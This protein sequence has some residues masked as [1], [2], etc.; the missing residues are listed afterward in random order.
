MP[1]APSA[2]SP[3]AA[4]PDATAPDT[5][6][7]IA[8]LAIAAAWWLLSDLTSVWGPSLITIFGQA[9]STPAELMGLFALGCVLVAIP[10]A[11]LAKPGPTLWVVLAVAVACRCVLTFTPGGQWQLWSASIG[12]AAA[13][14]W[15]A[16]VLAAHGRQVALGIALGWTI[17]SALGALG[18]T[19]SPVWRADV[20]GIGALVGL[21]GLLGWSATRLNSPAPEADI[22]P[23]GRRQAWTLLPLLLVTGIAIVNP[24]RASAVEPSYGATLLTIGSALAVLVA[25]AG[26]HGVRARV[27]AAVVSVAAVAA[28]LYGTTGDPV[29]GSL[30]TWTFI[31]FL[32]APTAFV[33]LLEPDRDQRPARLLVPLGGAVVWVLGFFAYY[34][35]YDLGYRADLLIVVLAAVI[36]VCAGLATSAQEQRSPEEF[37][38]TPRPILYV[39]LASILLAAGGAALNRMPEPYVFAERAEL[40]VTAWNLRM[41]YGMDGV[42]DPEAVAEI[43]KDSDVVLL[44]EIDRGWLLNG[45][46][47]QLA[48]LARLTDKEL[49]FAPAADPVWGDA[50]LTS[51]PVDEVRGHPLPSYG[52][53]TGAGALAVRLDLAEPLWVVS[54]HVQPTTEGEDGTI[55]QAGDLADLVTELSQDA[56][57]ILG[58]DFNF[59]PGSPSFR[60]ILD[61]GLV[62]ALADA[63]PLLTSSADDPTKQIDH[64]FVSPGLSV[65]ESGSTSSVASDHLPVHAVVK[66]SY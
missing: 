18:G 33:V 15:F 51:L 50:V 32:L 54:T 8:P 49:Y 48:I 45:G 42:F 29:P 52:A 53:V 62:D 41:G 59:E 9:A 17:T 24:G 21:V 43:I 55:E 28:S 4:T 38:L 11:W 39:L 12:L 2:T 16:R 30:A 31:V 57:V 6:R 5:G 64:L 13:L 46:Q 26:P 35:G 40:Q 60:A 25:L 61:T 66:L 20:I 14:A 65:L 36:A 58:G 23:I 22:Q 63:R 56:P 47:D 3:D 19:W 37:R 27:G 7:H 1:S 34:A 44:S 10:I